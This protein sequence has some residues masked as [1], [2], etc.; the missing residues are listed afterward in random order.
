M[1]TYRSFDENYCIYFMITEKFFFDKY[2][3]S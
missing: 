3:E 2:N 1:S